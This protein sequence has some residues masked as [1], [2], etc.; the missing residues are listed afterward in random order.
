M[1]KALLILLAPVFLV[2]ASCTTAREA[3]FHDGVDQLIRRSGML[4]EYR[5][6][7]E[8]DPKLKPETKAIRKDTAARLEALIEEE[9]KALED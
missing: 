3:A 7:V 4:A 8:A 9:R 2:A 6:Y 5:A 1:R